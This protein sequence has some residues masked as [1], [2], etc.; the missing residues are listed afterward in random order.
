MSVY[1]I[2]IYNRCLIYKSNVHCF[3][4]PWNTGTTTELILL[5]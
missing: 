1:I 4:L 2:Y 3:I 5:V